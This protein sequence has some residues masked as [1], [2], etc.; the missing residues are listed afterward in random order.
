MADQNRLDFSKELNRKLASE[1]STKEQNRKP[2][3]ETSETAPSGGL[4]KFRAKPVP[5]ASPPHP[6]GGIGILS[7]SSPL[8]PSPNEFD[9]KPLSTSGHG[10]L[11]S[12][13]SQQPVKPARAPNT[14][15]SSP[16]LVSGAQNRPP[17]AQ[18]QIPVVQA[19][20]L[21]KANLRPSPLRPS[22][23]TSAPPKVGT[24]SPP[25]PNAS[26]LLSPQLGRALPQLPPNQNV[27]SKKPLPQAPSGFR[28]P[29]LR[30]VDLPTRSPHLKPLP[31]PEENL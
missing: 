15:M 14:Q 23:P 28:S 9:S 7:A 21:S 1:T 24:A 11:E 29:T 12:A 19:G 10:N 8:R 4:A 6:L 2:P 26:R 20:D 22:S 25:N 30:P 3:L 16:H 27:P 18:P 5:G 31:T 17:R 13:P